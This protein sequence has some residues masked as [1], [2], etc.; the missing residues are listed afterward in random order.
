MPMPTPPAGAAARAT[1]QR[2]PEWCQRYSL[3]SVF[4]RLDGSSSLGMKRLLEKNIYVGAEHGQGLAAGASGKFKHGNGVDANG[5]QTPGLELLFNVDDNP[6]PVKVH[7][8]DRK[9][10]G[11]GVNAV[12]RVN[13]QS[14]A[15]GETGR[16]GGH[17]AA[18][19]GP[20]GACDPEIGREIG[21]AGAVKS[22]SRGPARGHDNSSIGFRDSPLYSHYSHPS[23]EEYFQQLN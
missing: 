2:F 18:K 16:V 6:F 1:E 10:H 23:R 5:G 7:G 9:A 12:G 15:A 4:M 21:G 14:L 22:V 3:A 11:E 17:E 13:P 20:V 8:V 19:A